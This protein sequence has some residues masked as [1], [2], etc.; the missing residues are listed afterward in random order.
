MS[1]PKAHPQQR[2]PDNKE[3]V[4]R[5]LTPPGRGGIA[6]IHLTGPGAIEALRPV[7]RPLSSHAAAGAHALQLGR[8]V[9]EDGAVLDE[10]V[11]CVTPEGIEINI[12]GGPQVVRSTLERLGQCGARVAVASAQHGGLPAA[13]PQ[14]DNPAVGREMLEAL[15]DAQSP[16][17]VAA[18]T[19]QWSAGLSRLA[20]QAL[21]RL[22][23]AE[24]PSG[25]RD[26]LADALRRAVR[27][28]PR[29]TRLLNPAEVVIVG[30]PNAGKSTLTNALVG[31]AVSIVHERAG[32]TRD[33]VRELALIGQVPV[34]LTD[35]AGLWQQAEGVDAEAV[36]RARRCAEQADVILLT[37]GADGDEFVFPPWL[38][39][40]CVIPVRTKADLLA[41]ERSGPTKESPREAS[42]GPC[43]KTKN[44]SR[45]LG[46]SALTGEGLP[47]LKREILRQLEL[48][49]FDPV[50]PM[51]FT[52][53]Q[54]RL[55]EQAA[56]AIDE[57]RVER[58]SQ[59]LGEL[60]AGP[61][62]DQDGTDSV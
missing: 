30:P 4:A 25:S 10:A 62:A 13:H 50:A 32:T 36:A 34:H 18:L 37:E 16:L 33:W 24:A 56:Q 27:A 43:P 6:V 20:R 2:A 28:L 60:L 48:D 57:G 47:E 42:R 7:F 35:T 5:L 46:V 49:A 61:P 55:L 11:V 58:A 26:D 17:A 51:A 31:R 59:Q 1:Q 44:A 22:A 29:M 9:G 52:A 14:L 21:A 45:A 8:I 3:P 53:R 54:V 39:G 40:Q 38:E 23:A 41:G 12:H 15:C 19:G